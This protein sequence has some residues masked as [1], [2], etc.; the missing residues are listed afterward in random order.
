[1]PG[2]KAHIAAGAGLAGG[3][4]G[5]AMYMGWF[6]AEPLYIALLVTIATLAALFPESSGESKGM[7]FFYAILFGLDIT[8]ILYDQYRWASVVGLFAMLPVLGKLGN[9]THSWWAMLLVPAPIM[10][11]PWIFFRTSWEDTLPYVAAAFVGYL[12]HLILDR[13]F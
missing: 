6:D 2:Y 1:M 4:I 7:T 9:W 8:L 11:L 5:G 13:Q 12:S 3:I 10:A